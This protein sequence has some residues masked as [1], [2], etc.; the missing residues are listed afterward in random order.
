MHQK[1][2]I[3]VAVAGAFTLLASA[4]AAHASPFHGAY[5]GGQLGWAS[6]DTDYDEGDGDGISGISASG[7]TGGAM[8]GFGTV[9]DNGLYLGGE[10]DFQSEDADLTVRL[11][12]AEL[13][14]DIKY[15]YGLTGRIGHVVNDQVL[16]YGL[17]GYQYARTDTRLS[18][19]GD[20]LARFKD[21]I[22]G[23]R[24]GLG[25]EYQ[26]DNRMFLRA[27]YSYTFFGR[28]TIRPEP[29]TTLRFDTDAS[30]FMLGVGYRF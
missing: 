2:R 4:S 25:V 11:E 19:D 24:L 28:E 1:T 3:G 12:D 27:E 8:A 5:V 14:Q 22:N 16:F 30:R 23:G 15:S 20:Q 17:A 7:F 26:M 21:N 18:E 29:G 9:L 13:G 6:Y 10:V